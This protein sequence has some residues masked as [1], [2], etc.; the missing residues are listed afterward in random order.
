MIKRK[1]PEKEICVVVARPGDAPIS[2]VIENTLKNFQD[3]VTGR[4]ETFP[5]WG[6]VGVC[7][8]E[9]IFNDMPINR[10]VKVGR[11]FVFGPVVITKASGDVFVPL[12]ADEV[13]E[14]M[15]RLEEWPV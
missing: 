3:L 5:F 13:E 14:V 9:G 7:N 10:R 12:S 11:Y 8:E 15:G 2:I 1:E 6:Y 4:I